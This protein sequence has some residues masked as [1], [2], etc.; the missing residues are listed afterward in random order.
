MNGAALDVVL[1][2]VFADVD[3]RVGTF[4]QATHGHGS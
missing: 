2:A 4:K 1:D 3:C